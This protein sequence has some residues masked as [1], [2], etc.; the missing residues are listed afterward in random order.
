[1]R[2]IGTQQPERPKSEL[3]TTKNMKNTALARLSDAY[4]PADEPR[5]HAE[6]ESAKLARFAAR[7]AGE[8]TSSRFA[9]NRV[10]DS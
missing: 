5:L 3:R 9:A 4:S 1:M 10:N 7:A 8:L 2:P 6:I